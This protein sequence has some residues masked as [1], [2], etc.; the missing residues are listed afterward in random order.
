MTNTIIAI[1]ISVDYSIH[2]THAF[3]RSKGSGTSRTI[4]ALD[5][6]GVAVFNG[7]FSTLL[8][9]LPISSIKAYIFRNFFKCWLGIVLYGVYFGLVLCPVLLAYLEP[10]SSRSSKKEIP[11][12]Q[13][14]IE[15]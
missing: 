6:A 1:G 7:G 14:L 3:L 13:S 8:A 11:V 15:L 12:G 5:T 4:Q 2:I 9:V 10:R